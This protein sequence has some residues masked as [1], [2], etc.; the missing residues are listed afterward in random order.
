MSDQRVRFNSLT[1]HA[2]ISASGMKGSLQQA[3]TQLQTA[4]R[5]G[6]RILPVSITCDV[7]SP[8]LC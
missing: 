8:P 4:I 2:Y 7:S 5:T 6:I 3:Y 1:L